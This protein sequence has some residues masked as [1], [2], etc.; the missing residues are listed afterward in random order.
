[1]YSS[2][3][4]RYHSPLTE[5]KLNRETGNLEQV[6]R[7]NN[8]PPYAISTPPSSSGKQQQKNR[9]QILIMLATCI[10]IVAIAL[11]VGIGFGLRRDVDTGTGTSPTVST[12]PSPSNTPINPSTDGIMSDTSVSAVLT[13]DN[14][15]HLFFQDVNGSLRH[16]FW[17]NSNNSWSIEADFLSVS[18]Q[19]QNNT[20]IGVIPIVA[21]GEGHAEDVSV[22]HVFFLS[23][24]GFLTATT[25]SLSPSG[26]TNPITSNPT[27]MNASFSVAK[28]SRLLAVDRIP[29]TDATALGQA[30]LFYEDPN[31]MLTTLI[32]TANF[33]VTDWSLQ[34]TWQNFT[35][36]MFSSIGSMLNVTS[37]DLRDWI[38]PPMNFARSD[39]NDTSCAGCISLSF[40]NNH[41]S[42][43]WNVQFSNW[44]DY[45]K[46]PEAL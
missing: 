1:M 17:A 30:A 10:A 8:H 20:P 40:F 46:P 7:P 18:S 14:N 43:V 5:T 11:G 32:G 41:D 12:A 37:H 27:P 13:G 3:I 9:K 38:E 36:V 22:I 29:M 4:L 42:K 35:D 24:E 16:T 26:P 25:Y 2:Q 44:S 6:A 23:E 34:W 45:G 15:K 28:G 21:S 39:S 31:G 19:P 33:S